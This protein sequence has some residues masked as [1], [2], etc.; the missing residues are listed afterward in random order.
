MSLTV[1]DALRHHLSDLRYRH[2]QGGLES[3]NYGTCGTPA[4]Q[5][6]AEFMGYTRELMDLCKA[7]EAPF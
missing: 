7:E 4:F 3:V 1:R 6:E 2:G 5:S